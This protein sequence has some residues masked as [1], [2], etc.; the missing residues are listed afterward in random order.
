MSRMMRRHSL[1]LSDASV[2]MLCF[3]VKFPTQTQTELP[4]LVLHILE[5]LSIRQHALEQTHGCSSACHKGTIIP[6]HLIWRHSWILAPQHRPFCTVKVKQ[7]HYKPGHAL[8]VPRGWVPQI[9]RHSA[10]EGGKVVSPT[11][12]LPLPPWNIP[13]THF[14]WRLSRSRAIVRPEGLCQ[15]KIP[16]TPSGIEPATF[17]LLAQCLN[18]LRHHVPPVCT[19]RIFNCSNACFGPMPCYN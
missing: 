1:R 18:Q 3:R 12:R 6:S 9:S 10:H 13:G 8:R 15:W 17:Q 4:L 5:P 2:G 19:V 7:C 16:I 11:H 14:C